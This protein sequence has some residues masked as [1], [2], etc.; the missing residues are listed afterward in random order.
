MVVQK[1]ASTGVAAHLISGCTVHHF[2][3]MNIHLE[4]YLEK[5]TPEFLSVQNASLIAIDE[6]SMLERT[7]LEKI[8]HIC[9]MS[10]HGNNKY[11]MFGGKNIILLGDPLQLPAIT[12]SI[13]SSKLWQLFKPLIL[14]DVKR[15]ADEK[16]VNLLQKVRVGVVDDEVENT[17]RERLTECAPT[18]ESDLHDAT[19][20]VSLRKERD[21]WNKKSWSQ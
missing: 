10:A 4:S 12:C 16:F 7:V 8:E 13:Y 19:I 3:R 2:F 17:L 5:G 20:I 9:R 15:Q 18:T 1:L 11:K 14:T 6:F 21:A